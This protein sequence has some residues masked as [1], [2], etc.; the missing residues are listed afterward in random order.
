MKISQRSQIN[1]MGIYLVVLGLWLIVSILAVW[2]EDNGPVG[3]H[4]PFVD[5]LSSETRFFL[6]VIFSSALGSSV[7]LLV[8]FVDQVTINAEVPRGAWW[9]YFLR[10]ITGVIVGLIV[11]ISIRGGILK[12]DSSV[13]FLNPY[14]VSG[15]AAISG[16]W[17]SQIIGRLKRYADSKFAAPLPSTVIPENSS[18]KSND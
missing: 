16:L 2:P 18:Q 8:K 1:L 5:S 7:A 15:I 11:Y 13:N 4:I 14:T 10:P 6:V 9:W 17:S 3:I 12:A